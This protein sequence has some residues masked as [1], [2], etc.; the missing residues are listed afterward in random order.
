LNVAFFFHVP[1]E[2]LNEMEKDITLT[3]N[4]LTPLW[5]GGVDGK[6]DRIHETGIIGSLRWWYEAIV[7]GLGG[8]ACD[9]TS[10]HKCHF[11]TE[12]YKTSNA[13]NETQRLRDAGLCDVCQIFGATGWKRQF[14]MSIEESKLSIATIESMIEA[15]RLNHKNKKPKWYFPDPTKINQ[16]PT[17]PNTPRIGSLT[18]SILSLNKL[19]NSEIIAGLICFIADWAAIG[20]KVQS[21]FGIVA[22]SNINT[23]PF[24]DQ[25]ITSVGIKSY[26]ELPNLQNIFFAV[27]QPTNKKLFVIQDTFNLKYDLRRLFEHDNWLRHFIM[28]SVK[29]DLIA[30]KVKI[31]SPYNNNSSI[32][33]WGWIPIIQNF[34]KNTSNRNKVIDR[35]HNHLNENYKLTVWQKM[36]SDNE[37]IPTNVTDTMHFLKKLLVLKENENVV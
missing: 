33:V 10:E 8:E 6:I 2:N 21:G 4:T 11:N 5:T 31:S 24:F 23:K 16:K 32:R 25:I 29:P 15:N 30:A 22:S 14:R 35:I 37:T 20:S 27:I 1:F 19:F 3:I 28:G 18:I 9:P 34:G 13:V 17:P 12:E 26:P 7:R 36:N